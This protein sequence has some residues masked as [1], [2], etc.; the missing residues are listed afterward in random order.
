MKRAAQRPLHEARLV[1]R[2]PRKGQLVARVTPEREATLVR[3]GRERALA[4]K[5]LVLTGLRSEELA[6]VRLADLDVECE[7]PTISLD[8][9]RTKNGEPATVV[10]RADLALDLAD[11]LADRLTVEREKH[12]T[13]DQ[14]VP[15]RL[16]PDAPLLRVPSIRV[17]DADLAFAEIPKRNAR[18]EVACRRSL[19]RTGATLLTDA[20]ASSAVVSAWMRHKG[21]TLA[22][23]VYTDRELLDIRRWLDLVAAL[24][25]HDDETDRPQQLRAT[26]SDGGSASQMLTKNPALPGDELRPGATSVRSKSGEASAETALQSPATLDRAGAADGTRTHD[27]NLGKVAL[28]H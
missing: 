20:G 22:Q 13:S 1:R 17:F 3:Q 12:R 21:D 9:T 8:G 24:P 16:D 23:R 7:L 5:A 19:R 4:Y 18:Q 2:G 25:L 27:I 11:W 14:P 6:S 10:L 15:T 26:G 28:Y